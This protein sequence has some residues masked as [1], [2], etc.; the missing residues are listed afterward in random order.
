METPHSI[1]NLF[2]M[3]NHMG[4]EENVL[5]VIAGTRESAR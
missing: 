3:M 5:G 2:W 1:R 4:G